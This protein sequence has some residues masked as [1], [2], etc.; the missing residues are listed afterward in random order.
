[1]KEMVIRPDQIPPELCAG[2]RRATA[3]LLQT[4]ARCA[5]TSRPGWATHD[6]AVA[7]AEDAIELIGAGLTMDAVAKMVGYSNRDTLR[8]ALLKYERAMKGSGG[9]EQSPVD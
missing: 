5:G 7:K 3:A 8:R 4:W 6:D 9:N 2:S 1:M